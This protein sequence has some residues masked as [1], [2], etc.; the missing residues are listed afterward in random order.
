MVFEQIS[1]SVSQPCEGYE[2]IV[3]CNDVKTGLKAIIGVHSTALGAAVGGCR[4]WGYANETE[5]LTDVLRL[6]K[7]MTYKAAISGLN[8][9]GGKAVI[10]GDPKTAKTPALLERFGEFVNRL[11]GTYVT[12]KDVG[13]GA[14]DLR[15]IKN[16]TCHVL[17]IDGEQASSGDPSPGTAW[18]VY[19]GMKSTARAAFGKDQLAGLTIAMQGLGSVSFYLIEHLLK[20]GAKVIGCDVDTA[21]IE[22]A[23]KTYGIQTVRP[24]AIYDVECDIFSPNALGATINPETRPRIRAKV[25]AG[26]ANN[27]L[28][29]PE[30]GM[31][32]LKRGMIY[33]PDYAINAGGLMNIYHESEVPGG[34][35]RERAFDH[36]AGIGITISKILERAKDERRPTSEIADRMAEERVLRGR[37]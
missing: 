14:E 7:G 34:Y 32:V 6:S 33:A 24:D 27:Q 11:G 13:I 5:A 25:I 4:M 21:A 9:G 2:Q 16:K 17:G 37:I 18:G 3:F 26:A 22:R 31:E 1:G 12:A 8:W 29:T 36:I 10:I 20:E 23:Q 15:A 35:A 30:M 28:S 19:H